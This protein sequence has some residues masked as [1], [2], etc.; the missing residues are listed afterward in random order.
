MSD[1]SFIISFKEKN[2]FNDN[3]KLKAWQLMWYSETCLGKRRHSV[4][5]D[6]AYHTLPLPSTCPQCVKR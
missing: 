2:T 6:K 5:P 4:L 3:P 1:K